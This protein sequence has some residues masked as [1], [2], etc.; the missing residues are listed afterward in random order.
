MMKHAALVTLLSL[1]TGG[2]GLFANEGEFT[3]GAGAKVLLE[4]RGP[5]RVTLE[6]DN[7][8]MVELERWSIAADGSET[9]EGA[10]PPGAAY[11]LA[12]ERDKRIL[13]VNRGNGTATVHYR[14]RSSASGRVEVSMR[15]HE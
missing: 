2:C 3:V 1:L 13:F 5:G 10:F 4:V 7:N 9:L 14:A 15:P 8:S 12:S 6:L 11:K